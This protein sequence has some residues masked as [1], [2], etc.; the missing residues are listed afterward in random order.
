MN[1]TRW[2]RVT[3]KRFAYYVAEAGEMLGSVEYD[4]ITN[5]FLE[6]KRKFTVSTG[7]ILLFDQ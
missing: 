4:N 1:R 6:G 5:V 7:N 3:T 2:V